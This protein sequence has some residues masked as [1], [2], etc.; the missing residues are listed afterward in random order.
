[1]KSGINKSLM[2]GACRHICANKRY[3]CC[4]M[5][6]TAIVDR[7][8]QMPP[9]LKG[10]L[11]KATILMVVWQ[12]LYHLVFVPTGIPDQQLKTL[13]GNI[14]AKMLSLFYNDV[15]A[16]DMG[17]TT[18]IVVNGRRTLGIAPACTG[19]ELIALYIGVLVCLPGNRKRMVLFIAGGIVGICLINSLRCALLVWIHTDYKML[20]DI[21]HKWVFKLAVYFAVFG[22]WYL[23]LKPYGKRVEE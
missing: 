19:L 2:N 23:Y 7:Y 4:L 16:V 10:F 12:F 6:I 3:F 22:G 14:T 17:Y 15:Q 9:Y 20:F 13:V 21:A 11:L 1:M 18:T 8:K 5:P